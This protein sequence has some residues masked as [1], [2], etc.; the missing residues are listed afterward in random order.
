MHPNP[1]KVSSK[2]QSLKEDSKSD[3]HSGSNL[4][5]SDLKQFKD[6]DVSVTAAPDSHLAPVTPIK[7]DSKGSGESVIG[8]THKKVGLKG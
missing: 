7:E 5:S 8:N 1:P 2:S 6:A 3:H 4:K